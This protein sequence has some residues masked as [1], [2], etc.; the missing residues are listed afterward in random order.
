MSRTLARRSNCRVDGSCALA[1]I[2]RAVETRKTEWKK[3]EEE[4]ERVCR[5]PQSRGAR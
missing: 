5:L 2:E 1:Q 3:T 4:K